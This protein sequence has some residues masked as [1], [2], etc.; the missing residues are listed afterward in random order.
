MNRKDIEKALRKKTSSKNNII[1]FIVTFAVMWS[2]DKLIAENLTDN[3]ILQL[4]ITL[5]I[6]F[7]VL[8]L[9]GGYV[10]S[11]NLSNIMSSINLETPQ[12]P[13][14]KQGRKTVKS[15]SKSIKRKSK[16]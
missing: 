3:F 5:P 11:R 1:I 4:I 15:T 16:K 2:V 8:S 14:A 6:G 12:T 9:I 10:L 7:V 13:R